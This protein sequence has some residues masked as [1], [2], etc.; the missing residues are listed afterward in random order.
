MLDISKCKYNS[1]WW[2]FCRLGDRPAHKCYF[3]YKD[4]YSNGLFDKYRNNVNLTDM[5]LK[6]E[7]FA[8][9]GSLR[10][11]LAM[12]AYF[13]DGDEVVNTGWTDLRYGEDYDDA[14]LLSLYKLA[15]QGPI[16]RMEHRVCAK[17]EELRKKLKEVNHELE[18][19][20]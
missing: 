20:I 16:D 15:A 2:T 6:L 18:S 7:V 17:F 4:F 5:E 9:D 14:I 1:D 8:Q 3:L 10:S 13:R 12:G 11:T 19:R